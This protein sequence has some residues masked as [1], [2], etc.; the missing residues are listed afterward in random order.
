MW[1]FSLLSLFCL[2]VS[3]AFSCKDIF[4]CSYDLRYERHFDTAD[5]EIEIVYKM[6]RSAVYGCYLRAFL[7]KPHRGN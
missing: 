1:G 7:N 4:N 3:T 5:I 6:N 2:V